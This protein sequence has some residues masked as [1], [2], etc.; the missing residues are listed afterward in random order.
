MGRATLIA[1]AAIFAL[2]PAPSWAANILG[3][4][5]NNE[6]KFEFLSD[7][8]CVEQ[9]ADSFYGPSCTTAGCNPTWGMIPTWRQSS[10]CT[11]APLSDGRVHLFLDGSSFLV[12]VT[13]SVMSVDNNGRR[14][15]YQR[16]R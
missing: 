9:H 11:W 10:F 6:Q 12:T 8:T 14:I 4:W 3:K 1:V 5:Q 2:S 13:D 16:A 15:N 7:K